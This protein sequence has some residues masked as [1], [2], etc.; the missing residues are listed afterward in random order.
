[1]R[2]IPLYFSFALALAAALFGS[3][4]FPYLHL[5]FFA[6]FLALSYHA[7][8]L[9]KS[10]WLSVACGLI[11]DLIS[12]E[13]RFGLYTLTFVIT[14]LLLY[15]QKRHFFEDKP[16][17]L[18]LFSAAIAAV[19]I[20]LQFIFVHLF[21]RGIPFSMMSAFVDGIL[22]SAVDGIYAFLWFTCPMRLYIYIRKVGWKGL[23]RKPLHEEE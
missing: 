2:T 6:P 18:S 8:P 11:L 1:M 23:F 13:F 22:M 19:L 12:S 16:L 10:V 21:D 9:S 7:A 5:S 15:A 3:V 4:F 14:T 17:A 20:F